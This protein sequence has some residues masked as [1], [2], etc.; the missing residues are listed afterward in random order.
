MILAIVLASGVTG[1][2][3]LA[4]LHYFMSAA[5]LACDR[6]ESLYE[7]GLASQ[8]AGDTVSAA[9]HWEQ[10]KEQV[11]AAL[12][13]L[14]RE[15]A[16]TPATPNNLN[17]FRALEGRCQWLRMKALRD[18]AYARAANDRTTLAAIEDST[19]GERFPHPVRIPDLAQ[20]QDALAALYRAAQLMP[21]NLE[22]QK[23]SLRTRLMIPPVHWPSVVAA[24]RNVRAI[25]PRDFRAGYALARFEFEQFDAPG[26]PTPPERRDFERIAKSREILA[27]ACSVE[28]YP[29][30]RAIH[31]DAQITTWLRDH[32]LRGRRDS[33][34]ARES[35]RLGKLLLA[36]ET[37]AVARAVRGDGTARLVSD[38]DINGLIGLQ[39]MA[40]DVA[41]SSPALLQET[42]DRIEKHLRQRW[43]ERVSWSDDAALAIV[44]AYGRIQPAFEKTPAQWAPRLDR[45]SEF[46]AATRERPVQRGEFYLD[47]AAVFARESDRCAY[48][49]D[50]NRCD[51]MARLAIQ[52]AADGL[53]RLPKGADAAA[54][55]LHDLLA[56]RRLRAGAPREMIGL[57]LIE[58]AKSRDPELSA[59]R[60][61]CLGCLAE[62]DL[63]LAAS[64][65][66]FESVLNA[67]PARL[68]SHAHLHLGSIYLAMGE[69][70]LALQ[71]LGELESLVNAGNGL[72][73]TIR[74]ELRET[75]G[76]IDD[77][78]L[79]QIRA[80]LE[81][82][83]VRWARRDP[84]SPVVPT[85]IQED[86]VGKLLARLTAAEHIRE[87]RLMWADYL[88]DTQRMD[89][90]RVT[91]AE[92]KRE[93]PDHPRVRRLELK[94]E[95]GSVGRADE[96]LRQ[97]LAERPDDAA[98][99]LDWVCRLLDTNRVAQALEATRETTKFRGL[100]EWHEFLKRAHAT[101]ELG[102]WLS[103]PPVSGSFASRAL[104]VAREASDG[105]AAMTPGL[106]RIEDGARRS[107]ADAMR[108]FGRKDDATAASV[109]VRSLPCATV[110]PLA[111]E[112]TW[113]SLAELARN[114]PDKAPE[115]AL[116]LNDD[117]PV[118]AVA[119]LGF[120]YACLVRDELGTPSDSWSRAKT[121]GA[122]LNEW[123]RVAGRGRSDRPALML[124]KVRFWERSGRSDYA[125]REVSRAVGLYPHHSAVLEKAIELE[126][127]ADI[128]DAI[129]RAANHV[130]AILR[131]APESPESLLCKARFEVSLG[132]VA[133]ALKTCDELITK[134]P[135]HGEG[136]QLLIDL[137]ERQGLPERA[138]AAVR[139]WRVHRP[140]DPEA[141][142][143]EV[144]LLA[145]SGDRIGAEK[146]AGAAANSANDSDSDRLKLLVVVAR[147]LFRAGATDSAAGFAMKSKAIQ[148]D[149][150]D[151]RHLLGD[152]DAAS[153]AWTEAR[154]HYAFVLSLDR[155][156]SVV[157]AKLAR[158][159]T[160]HLNDAGAALQL[161]RD[162]RRD[163]VTGKPIATER[164]SPAILDTIGAIYAALDQKSLYSEMHELFSTARDRF[165]LDARISLHLAEAYVGLGYKKNATEALAATATLVDTQKRS[166][167]TPERRRQILDTVERL[168]SRLESR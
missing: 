22:V 3:Y 115:F 65:T 148:P 82:A 79:L 16:R 52:V 20:R 120:A 66:Y 134:F 50:P 59:M 13:E 127:A 158:L 124:T 92:L 55:K 86:A 77:W 117:S 9:R 135:R 129:S 69:P 93:S 150:A 108:A 40:L 162:L 140:Q 28:G 94:T 73:P 119:L 68:S 1:G 42:H 154:A 48:N 70:D 30:W 19:T 91:V 164:L 151:V 128:P 74:V 87:G 100:H 38:L 81:L 56:E 61:Y 138:A 75:I 71:S 44:A 143:E 103:A 7:S 37:G 34:A 72:S 27:E 24:A 60:D 14:T 107:I 83:A 76:G 146:L 168:R 118:Q 137:A 159:L 8:S 112:G 161:A 51:V 110:H 85:R 155:N 80:H 18:L 31:L 5:R 33:D 78:L 58:L 36:P 156:H 139:A 88:C 145:I 2:A 147:A 102:S 46:V 32:Y 167:I 153:K 104:R 63:R 84:N 97:R 123:E 125:L 43:A 67:K 122:A 133:Q 99:Q 126:L 12:A 105:S 157:A 113:R 116:S 17:L 144:R 95:A 25:E 152:L 49:G 163:S 89:L 64:R 26:T 106:R 57:H 53:D 111:Y 6:A 132:K 90:A 35:D 39:L 149:A 15:A 21:E 165:P 130:D 160:T 166:A 23:E 10:A 41:M 96:I 11:E 141:I 136:Y 54:A 29:I 101:D 62:R 131:T 4:Y 98:L 109:F 114:H 142:A 121:M 47:A 45:L